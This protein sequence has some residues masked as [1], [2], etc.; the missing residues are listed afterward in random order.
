MQI[1][2]LKSQSLNKK[3]VFVL[4]E[5]DEN[6]ST[7]FNYIIDLLEEVSSE[8]DILLF[9]EYGRKKPDISRIQR[10]YLQKMQIKGL[11]LIERFLVFLW[12]RMCGYKRF[13]VHYSYFSAIIAG[14]ISR[15]TFAKSFAWYCE[16]KNLYS[17]GKFAF[18]AAIRCI[19]KIVTCTDLMAGYYNEF[20]KIKKSK[21]AVMHNWVD[22]NKLTCKKDQGST[23]KTILFV[24][25]LS[26]RKGS[27]Y[28][29]DIIMKT[30]DKFP[31]CKFVIV[32]DGPDYKKL[33][34]EFAGQNVEF[35]GVVPNSRISKYFCMADVFIMPSREEEFGRVLL[36]AMAFGVPIVAMETFGTRA[37]LN[38]EQKKFMVKQGD[39][40]DFSDKVVKLLKNDALREELSRTGYLHVRNFDQ[41]ISAQKFIEIVR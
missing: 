37:V 27:E 33:R 22:L 17:G 35:V 19:Q 13:Y 5:Y 10:V 3:L 41:H 4:P 11:N 1:N 14:L 12:F 39:I 32:G 6:S 38:N 29:S 36:E 31:N 24:H 2:T 9:I 18:K 40:E 15:F 34:A 30:F 28:L 20:F 7:H 21:I 26:P 16:Q 8:M 23:I 25:W